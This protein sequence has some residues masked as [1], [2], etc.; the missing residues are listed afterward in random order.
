MFAELRN[1]HKL[2]VICVVGDTWEGVSSWNVVVG[3]LPT[4]ALPV[5]LRNYLESYQVPKLF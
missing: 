2:L 4:Y 5:K 3:S 1:L